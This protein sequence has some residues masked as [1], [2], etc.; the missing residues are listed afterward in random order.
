MDKP[1]AFGVIWDDIMLGPLSLKKNNATDAIAAAASIRE[2]GVGKVEN[3]RA[4]RVR[5]GSDE[6][7]YLD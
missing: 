3:V 6:L 5:E 4:V 2:R 7:E 1:E